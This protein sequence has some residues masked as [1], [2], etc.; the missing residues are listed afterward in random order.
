MAELVKPESSDAESSVYQL[1]HPCHPPDCHSDSITEI[2]K[3]GLGNQADL[4]IWPKYIEAEKAGRY[5]KGPRADYYS[6]WWD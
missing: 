1:P 2:S 6:L 4:E 3:A 5:G